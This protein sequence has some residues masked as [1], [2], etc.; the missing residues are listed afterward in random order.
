M[1]DHLLMGVT[2]ETEVA[3]K[4]SVTIKKKKDKR[5]RPL[6]GTNL[7]MDV[8]HK[9]CVLLTGHPFRKPSWNFYL[10]KTNSN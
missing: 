9:L 1:Q 8:Q 2:T 3:T 7:F 10:A 6:Q 5:G 4:K